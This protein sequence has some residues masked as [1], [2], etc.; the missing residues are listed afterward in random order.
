[1]I[2]YILLKYFY[3]L[4]AS[5]EKHLVSQNIYP[6]ISVIQLLTKN[7]FVRFSLSK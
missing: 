4:L 3:D 2:S 6:H 1:M 7:I 5:L